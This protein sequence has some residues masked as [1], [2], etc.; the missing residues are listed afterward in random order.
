MGHGGQFM[1]TLLYQKVTLKH[2][3]FKKKG[4]QIWL[5]QYVNSK[6]L[7]KIIVYLL[8]LSYCGPWGQFLKTITLQLQK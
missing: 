2:N 7:I 1:K 3:L 8:H 4:H 5:P 6:V